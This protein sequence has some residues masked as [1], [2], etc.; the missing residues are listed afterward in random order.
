VT[1]CHIFTELMLLVISGSGELPRASVGASPAC[2]SVT[3]R[4][5]PGPR[6]RCYADYDIPREETNMSESDNSV[7]SI[8]NQQSDD[9][10]IVIAE[11][12]TIHPASDGTRGVAIHDAKGDY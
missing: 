10:P 1:E 9:V 4:Q 8:L 7:E 2:P 11:D 3:I 5:R 12:G 6:G